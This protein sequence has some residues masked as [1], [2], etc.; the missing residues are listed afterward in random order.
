MVENIALDL[1][2]VHI[3]STRGPVKFFFSFPVVS[4]DTEV[5]FDL[6]VLQ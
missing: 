3:N 1:A 4:L 2:L 5:Y 6:K